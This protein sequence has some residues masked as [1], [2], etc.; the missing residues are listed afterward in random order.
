MDVAMQLLHLG[1][2]ALNRV[3]RAEGVGDEQ[4]VV[5]GNHRIGQVKLVEQQFQTR[6][7]PDVVQRKLNR[8]IEF[9][10]QA[11]DRGTVDHDRRVEQSAQFPRSFVERCGLREREAERPVQ[12]VLH[13]GS[14]VLLRSGDLVLRPQRKTGHSGQDQRRDSQRNE[15]RISRHDCLLNRPSV[16]WKRHCNED[17]SD[18][19]YPASGSTRPRGGPRRFRTRWGSRNPRDRGRAPPPPRHARRRFG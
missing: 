2:N 11:I 4:E 19:H 6:L 3:L 16:A 12:G 5:F 17:R 18:R 9:Q 15:R 1:T 14:G 7:E 8:V 13:G 10:S